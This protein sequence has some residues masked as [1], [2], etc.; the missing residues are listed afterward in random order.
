MTDR[1]DDPIDRLRASREIDFD[2]FAER[3]REEAE[4]VKRH[5]AAGA[6]DNADTAVGL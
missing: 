6:F 3:V 4:V 1:P 2:E 5:V